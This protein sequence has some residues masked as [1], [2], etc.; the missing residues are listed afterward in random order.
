MSAQ[1]NTNCPF[2]LKLTGRRG[3]SNWTFCTRIQVRDNLGTHQLH[4]LSDF[5]QTA[6]RP[7]GASPIILGLLLE[8]ANF[9]FQLPSSRITCCLKS[10]CLQS[11]ARMELELRDHVYQWI[12][13]QV[14]SLHAVNSSPSIMR[15]TKDY[16]RKPGLFRYQD[17]PT[18]PTFSECRVCL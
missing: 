4:S 5:R 13:S 18:L 7:S 17:R 15:T 14:A 2:S 1:F 11:D 6:I 16:N 10:K 12:F 9:P 8:A 3:I